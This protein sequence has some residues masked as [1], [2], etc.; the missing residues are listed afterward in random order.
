M[1]AHNLVEMEQGQCTFRPGSVRH[2]GNKVTTG[3]RYILGGFLLISDR[4]EHVRRLNNQGREARNQGDL[5]RARRLFRWALKI[6]PKC[7]TCLKNWA[8]AIYGGK[9]GDG[10]GSV[11]PKLAEVPTDEPELQPHVA[12]AAALCVGGCSPMRRRLRP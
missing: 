4:V 9:M 12:E 11:P 6:N 2:G 7:A 10:D 3:E 1:G 8:E 5:P